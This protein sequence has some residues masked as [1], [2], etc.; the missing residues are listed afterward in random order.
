MIP[1]AFFALF[2]ILK[3]GDFF[4]IFAEF[5]GDFRPFY[6]R[7]GFPGDNQ[8]PNPAISSRKTGKIK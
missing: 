2:I 3:K 6:L 4:E 1:P 7:T 5:Q 8:R